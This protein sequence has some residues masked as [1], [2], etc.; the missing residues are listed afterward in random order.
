MSLSLYPH[1]PVTDAGAA[2]KPWLGGWS[3]DEDT[4][5][6]NNVRFPWFSRG[7]SLLYRTRVE[8]LMQPSLCVARFIREV[9]SSQ[10]ASRFARLVPAVVPGAVLRAPVVV[11]HQGHALACIVSAS[12]PGPG[13][14]VQPTEPPFAMTA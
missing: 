5:P 8:Y 4:A 6:A 7:P 2:P 11:R 9:L 14:A 10:A 12:C 3:G 13:M 1:L